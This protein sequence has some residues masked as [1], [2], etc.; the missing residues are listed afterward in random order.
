MDRENHFLP[1]SKLLELINTISSERLEKEVTK[2]L[3]NYA[4]KFTS[5]VISR[6]ILFSKH[7]GSNTVE[8][9]DILF[10]V[11]KEFDYNF[12]TRQISNVVNLPTDEHK[13]RMAELSRHK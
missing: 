5:D 3:Q 1:K 11:E 12:G 2:N 8:S 6:S 7:R 4:E 10:T 9:E 13:E